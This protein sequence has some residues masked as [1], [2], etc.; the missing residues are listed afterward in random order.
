MMIPLRFS[1]GIFAFVI[2]YKLLLADLAYILNLLG[3]IFME[4]VCMMVRAFPEE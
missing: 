2:L 3:Q 4:N 1:R